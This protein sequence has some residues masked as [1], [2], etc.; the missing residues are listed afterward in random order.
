MRG[1]NVLVRQNCVFP[2][3]GRG[4]S[5]A[6]YC[7]AD[8]KSLGGQNEP[9]PSGNVENVSFDVESWHAMQCEMPNPCLTRAGVCARS[10]HVGILCSTVS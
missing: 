3:C 1:G 5:S 8:N 6:M 2:V 7:A 4:V 9:A 10:G